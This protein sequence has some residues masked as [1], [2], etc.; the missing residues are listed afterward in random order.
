[1]FNSIHRDLSW[2]GRQ[3]WLRCRLWIDLLCCNIW[4]AV[5]V[6]VWNLRFLLFWFWNVLDW[7]CALSTLNSI[8]LRFFISFFVTCALG[9]I[10]DRLCYW[11]IVLFCS[12]ISKVRMFECLR[13][14]DSVVGIINQEFKNEILSIFWDMLYQI[15]DSSS[16]L[17]GK[18]ELHVWGVLLESV[19][20]FLFGSTQYV[21]NFMNLIKF[22]VAWKERN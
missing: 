12:Q 2:S 14:C 9:R 4:L 3:C 15:C 7:I 21:M 18:V 6:F 22:I 17:W 13:C 5:I 1:M 20:K 8:N 10:H 16:F 11:K 19:K